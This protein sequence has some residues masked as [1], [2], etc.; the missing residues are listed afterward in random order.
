MDGK[1]SDAIDLLRD[2]LLSIPESYQASATLDISS[3]LE[4]GDAVTEISISYYRPETDAEL[5][6][7]QAAANILAKQD[8]DRQR[9]EYER[10]RAK[11]G[12]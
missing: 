12:A 1:L 11:F 2:E 8:E 5:S 4:Y 3:H 6:A 9:A 10:L 7:R